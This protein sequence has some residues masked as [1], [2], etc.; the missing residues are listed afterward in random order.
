MILTV[1]IPEYRIQASYAN[2]H[3]RLVDF[4]TPDGLLGQ[5]P[6]G[7][8]AT[9]TAFESAVSNA[10]HNMDD[11]WVVQYSGGNHEI[12]YSNNH[13]NM[14]VSGNTGL[15]NYVSTLETWT[16]TLA[17]EARIA[18]IPTW[19]DIRFMRDEKLRNS[20]DIVAWATETGNTIPSNWTTY[21]QALRDLTTTYGAPSGNTEL[22]VIPS[23]PA[24]P[25]A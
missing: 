5:I 9:K 10:G 11:Y 17:E 14:V 13:G 20:D 15:S 7:N 18:A 6:A 3:V 4:Y 12:E 24:W 21:R 22:V 25:S 8:T 2:G 1:I 19:D 16:D 23:R